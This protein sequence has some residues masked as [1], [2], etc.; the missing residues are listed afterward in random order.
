[1]LS[2][3]LNTL[4][5][6]LRFV[7]LPPQYAWLGPVIIF[8]FSLALLFSGKRTWRVM[9]AA[10]GAILGYELFTLY[11]VSYPAVH[12][13][14][15]AHALPMPLIDMIVAILSAVLFGAI[16]EGAI[17]L[18]IGYAAFY[19]SSY[20]APYILPYVSP[21]YHYAPIYLWVTIGFIV[22]FIGIILYRRI[23]MYIAAALGAFGIWYTMALVGLSAQNAT[24]IAAILLFIGLYYQS[25]KKQIAKLADKKKAANA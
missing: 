12:T 1:M 15:I 3:F 9:T 4:A 13:F 22:G 2:S 7:N 24:Y 11:V 6:Y 17:V 20:F 8:L 14:I 10:I 25:H 5:H 19:L 18:A 16:V 23:T 21:Y